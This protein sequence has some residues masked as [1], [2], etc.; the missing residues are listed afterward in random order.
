MS[1]LWGMIGLIG[2]TGCA[3]LQL[4]D[5]ADHILQAQGFQPVQGQVTLKAWLRT[6]PT[7]SATPLRRLRVYIEGDGAAWWSHTL[8][9]TDPTPGFSVALDL[10]ASDAHTDVAYLARPCQYLNAQ[11]RA[12]CPH[13]WWTDAR[14]G[15][16]VQSQMQQRLDLMIAQ[17]GAGQLELIGH[18]GGGTMAVLLAATRRDV[19][20]LVTLAAPLDL[21]A[22]TGHHR[23]APLHLSQDPALL[24]SGQPTA[25]AAYLFG[26][27][28]GVVPAHTI[29]RYAQRL[30]PG[31]LVVMPEWGHTRGWSHRD[32]WQ[33]HTGCMAALP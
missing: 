3:P 13:S 2:L 19:A 33:A 6:G 22:W 4:K 25:P 18:S 28:D 27:R 24:P 16:E 21:Q 9:P 1:L 10:A 30:K 31:Q 12:M 5:R 11:T 17:S 23:V 7:S 20:C 29:G 14:H 15:T 32:A 26:E 8:P